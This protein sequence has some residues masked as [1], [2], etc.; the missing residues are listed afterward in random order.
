MRKFGTLMVHLDLV[1]NG[2]TMADPEADT[3]AID[4]APSDDTTD[5]GQ[6]GMITVGNETPDIGPAINVVA[7]KLN[8]GTLELKKRIH[9]GPISRIITF[10]AVDYSHFTVELA[11]MAGAIND[12]ATAAGEMTPYVPFGGDTAPILGWW[13]VRWIDPEDTVVRQEVVW[14]ELRLSGGLAAGTGGAITPQFSLLVLVNA[15]NRGGLIK[16]SDG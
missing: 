5:W 13:R 4:V 8:G 3:A 12:T 16:Q 6:L 9:L 14:G 10:T 2:A 15:L 11:A 1:R 7:P